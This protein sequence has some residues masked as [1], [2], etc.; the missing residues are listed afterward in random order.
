MASSS[1]SHRR[2]D[3][4]GAFSGIEPRGITRK[5]DETNCSA[6]ALQFPYGA[7]NTYILLIRK[8]KNW[9]IHFPSAHIAIFSSGYAESPW[10]SVEL[11]L[12]FQSGDKIFPVFKE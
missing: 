2:N 10:C 7:W 1:A 11:L 12:M 4:H 5:L 8:R 3:E 9:A 6:S